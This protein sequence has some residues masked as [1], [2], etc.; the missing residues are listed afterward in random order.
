MASKTELR[1]GS[2]YFVVDPD[3]VGVVGK[4][5]PLVCH[6]RGVHADHLPHHS[7]FKHVFTFAGD[8]DTGYWLTDTMVLTLVEPYSEARNAEIAKEAEYYY[9][10]LKL[11]RRAARQYSPKRRKTS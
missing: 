6:Y 8:P 5:I 1:E 2:K 3:N 7:G 4:R 11:W 9:K 10:Y